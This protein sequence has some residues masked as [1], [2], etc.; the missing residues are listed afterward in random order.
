M[1]RI[2]QVLE[3]SLEKLKDLDGKRLDGTFQRKENPQ[4]FLKG[5]VGLYY[6]DI[7]MQM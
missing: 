3:L 1:W 7:K 4:N 5:N 2:W 6:G